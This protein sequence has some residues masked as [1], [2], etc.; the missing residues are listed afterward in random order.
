MHELFDDIV[1]TLATPLPRRRVLGRIAGL[2]AGAALTSLW[3]ERAAAGA[4]GGPCPPGTR[5]SPD[6]TCIPVGQPGGGGGCPNPGEIRCA[7]TC[8]NVQTD[9]ANCGVCGNQCE[10]PFCVAGQCSAIACAEYT[11]CTPEGP[12]DRVPC[13]PTNPRFPGQTCWVVVTTTGLCVCIESASCDDP[14]SDPD[15]PQPF[16]CT[17]DAECTATFGTPSVCID[18]GVFTG[19]NPNCGC[20]NSNQ[21]FCGH[22]CP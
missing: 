5:R 8:V 12:E 22:L 17:T 13:T 21:N 1:R 15:N 16:D 4:Q 9:S 11:T 7:G 14:D 3:P 18:G 19:D 2:L 6:G 20:N 10:E